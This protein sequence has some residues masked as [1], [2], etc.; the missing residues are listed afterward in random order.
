M[1]V[2]KMIRPNC[3]PTYN[4]R[5]Q[6]IIELID[7]TLEKYKAD[8]KKTQQQNDEQEVIIDNIIE[9]LDKKRNLAINK[10][11]QALLKDEVWKYGGEE[12]TI[13]YVLFRIRE[14]TGRLI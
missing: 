8:I 6:K 4:E 14:L 1:N 13:D 3:H 10:K 12:D 2:K 9:E 7:W 11:Q 5:H